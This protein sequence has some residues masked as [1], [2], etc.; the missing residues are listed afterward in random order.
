MEA[1]FTAHYLNERPTKYSKIA[2]P[3]NS[4]PKTILAVDRNIMFVKAEDSACV[5]VEE[6]V[7]VDPDLQTQPEQRLAWQ[8]PDIAWSQVE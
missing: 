6:S 4:S 7:A 1:I 8:S 5:A 3:P 2:K